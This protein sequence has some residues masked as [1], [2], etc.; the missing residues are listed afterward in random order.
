MSKINK[1]RKKK[2]VTYDMEGFFRIYCNGSKVAEFNDKL[3]KS[4]K[5]LDKFLKEKMDL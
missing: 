1:K 4:K 2:M 5:E 3:D